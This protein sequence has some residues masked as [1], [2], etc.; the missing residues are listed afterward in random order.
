MDAALLSATA[1]MFNLN[2]D[3]DDELEEDAAGDDSDRCAIQ[4]VGLLHALQDVT[5]TM[6]LVEVSE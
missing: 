5:G 3:D 2:V 6:Y 1:G 4:V